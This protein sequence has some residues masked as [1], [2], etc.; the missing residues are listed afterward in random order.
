MVAKIWRLKQVCLA[1]RSTTLG[2]APTMIATHGAWRIAGVES[3]RFE[4]TKMSVIATVDS[5]SLGVTSEQ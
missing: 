5:L 2:N 3:A 4:T 1:A